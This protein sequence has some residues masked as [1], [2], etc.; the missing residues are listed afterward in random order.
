MHSQSKDTK[1][2]VIEMDKKISHAG[3]KFAVMHEMFIPNIALRIVARA[4]V[5]SEFTNA[6]IVCVVLELHTFLT[7]ELQK[8]LK[9]YPMTFIS[10][11]SL[12]FFFWYMM[13][14]GDS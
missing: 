4:I 3:K 8:Q 13:S 14:Q 7:P 1:Q 6:T 11:V 2:S 10:T 5:E 12:D 9:D